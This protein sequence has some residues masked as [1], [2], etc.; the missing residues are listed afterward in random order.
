MRRRMLAVGLA[1]AAVLAGEALVG[2]AQQVAPKIE[3]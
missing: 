3:P 1:G 2:G